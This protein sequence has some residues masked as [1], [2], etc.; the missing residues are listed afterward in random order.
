MDL[1]SSLIYIG[2]VEDNETQKDQTEEGNKENVTNEQNKE[3][4]TKEKEKNENVTLIGTMKNEEHF[5]EDPQH[6]NAVLNTIIDASKQ[7]KTNIFEVDIFSLS[8]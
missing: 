6:A 8:F 3:E 4:S 1:K 2:R 5:E 7:H